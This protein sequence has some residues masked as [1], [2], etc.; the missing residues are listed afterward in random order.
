MK[1]D[2]EE[3]PSKSQLKRDAEALQALGRK[4]IDLDDLIL[5]RMPLTESLHKA[6]LDAK[7]IKSHGA[8]RRQTQLIG[9]LMRAADHEAIATAYAALQAKDAMQSAQFHATELWRDKLI[10]G[11]AEALNEFINTFQPDDIQQLR[12]VL[13]KVTSATSEAKQKAARKELFRYI[14]EYI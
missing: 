3:R 2:Y 12:Q 8:L 9:K 11:G 4:L 13:K 5:D 7:R 10:E 6:V 1:D 14:R